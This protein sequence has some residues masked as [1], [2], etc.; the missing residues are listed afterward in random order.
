MTNPKQ[1]RAE[2]LASDLYWLCV[3]DGSDF[4]KFHSRKK[5]ES[6]AVIVR[7]HYPEPPAEP[8]PQVMTPEEWVIQCSDKRE[9]WY[10]RML[11]YAAYCVSADRAPACAKGLHNSC[12]K[13]DCPCE[14]CKANGKH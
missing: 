3:S 2:E 6:I 13:L 5:I 11:Y 8:T 9:T 12:T 1:D 14:T 4:A 7:K 10:E